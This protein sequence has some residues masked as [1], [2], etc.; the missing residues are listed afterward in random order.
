MQ[1]NRTAVFLVVAVVGLIGGLW[2]GGRFAGSGDASV[3][4]YLRMASTLY[5]EGESIDSVR[6]RLRW[7][8]GY[9]L[10]GTLRS[11]ADKYSRSNDPQKVREAAA[12]ARLGEAIATAPKP[13]PTARPKPGTTPAAPV[14]TAGPLPTVAAATPGGPVP[15]A[16]PTAAGGRRAPN[17][18]R[19]LVVRPISVANLRQPDHPSSASFRTNQ[20]C[21]LTG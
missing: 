21:G 3:E 5:A 10:P 1:I 4:A 16:Q 9:D 6:D 14:P 13:G 15:A 18:E 8:E 2:L 11:L 19:S 20:E 17:L 12:L 7:M